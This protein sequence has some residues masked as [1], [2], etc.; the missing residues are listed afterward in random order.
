MEHAYIKAFKIN[1]KSTMIL[2]KTYSYWQKQE[3]VLSLDVEKQI[4]NGFVSHT[5]Y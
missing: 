1:F 3:W 5:T 4:L 2:A